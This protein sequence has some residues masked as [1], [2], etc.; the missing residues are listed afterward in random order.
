MEGSGRN[1]EQPV[2]V[3]VCAWLVNGRSR[4]KIKSGGM[5]DHQRIADR[6][7]IVAYIPS[8]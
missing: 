7:L 4:I 3:A 2:R 6:R 5:S 8:T 1:V